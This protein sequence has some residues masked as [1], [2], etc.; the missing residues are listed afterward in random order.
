LGIYDPA[1]PEARPTG[2]AIILPFSSYHGR[3]ATP[4][5]DWIKLKQQAATGG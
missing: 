3:A 1:D 2:S 5:W 4:V